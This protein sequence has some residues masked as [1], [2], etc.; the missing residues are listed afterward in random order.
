MKSSSKIGFIYKYIPNLRVHCI[1]TKHE[2]TLL[3]L[4]TSPV[5]EFSLSICNTQKFICSSDD[6]L[7]RLLI[8]END[9]FY[10]SND[11]KNRMM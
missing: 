7:P 10:K 8:S 6:D 11:Y 2:V 3:K 4:K 9:T 1:Q 5:A